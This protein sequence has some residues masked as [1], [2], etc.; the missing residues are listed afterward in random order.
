[1]KILKD[2]LY[3]VSLNS[4]IG[5]MDRKISELVFD[6]RKVVEDSVFVAIS[7]TQVDGHVFIDAALDKGAKVIVCETLPE[8]LHEEITYVQVVNSAR[9][10][11]IMAAN[12]YEN[13][14]EKL[15]IVAVTGTNGKTTTATLLYQ[16][17]IE[18]GYVVGLLSTVEN[19]ISG[20]V[21]PSTHTTPDSLSMQSLLKEMVDE[22]CTHCFMEASSHAIVQERTAGIKLTGAV[23]TNITHDHLDYHGTFDEYIKAKKK[24]FDELPKDAFALIN[25]DDKRAMVMLQNTKATRQSF[26]LKYPADFKAKILTNA[27]EGLELDINGKQVWFRMIGEFNAYNLL[28]VL[29]T[30]V[31][32]GEDE[33]EILMQ[34]SKVEG[35]QGRFDKIS[36]AGIT[37]IVDY[38]HTP[39]AL[40]NVLKTIQGVRSGGEQVITIVGC[41]G[42]RDK[43]KRPIMAKIATQLSDKVILTSDNPRDED[44]MTILKEMEAGINPV[45]FKKTMIIEDRREAIKTAGIMANKGDI[46]LIA[47][48]GHETYQEIKGVKHPFDDRAVV[49]ELLNLLNQ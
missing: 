4:T 1:M 22:G 34:L 18:M 25:A 19:K 38:A 8:V 7:G 44:P 30:A 40:E 10:L 45:N 36:I 47:G 6:S 35:A 23:F 39:D 41:G 31:L 32:L 14:S 27:L 42:N 5:N 17:F 13:P 21:I 24:L 46:I 11:G 49:K 37:A 3:R 20:K 33:E 29:A 48:K 28:G 12:Y 16:L 9:A 43:T 15:K 26:G 2:I